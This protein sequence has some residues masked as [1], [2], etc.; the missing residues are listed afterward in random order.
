MHPDSFVDSL[1]LAFGV[2]KSK[3]YGILIHNMNALFEL[4]KTK[5]S[6]VLRKLFSAPKASIFHMGYFKE[7][8]F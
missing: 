3:F 8:S 1:M 6:C 4:N 2:F 7:P 5:K